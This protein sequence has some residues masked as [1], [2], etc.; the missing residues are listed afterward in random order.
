MKNMKDFLLKR[1][2]LS[3]LI[4]AF[5]LLFVNTAFYRDD[6]RNFEITKNMDI[7]FSIFREVNTFYVDEIDPGIT[8]KKAIDAMLASL[9]PY[10][11][12]YP[13]S[14]IEDFRFM[15][16][17]EYGGIG[18]VVQKRS[19]SAII[20]EIYENT[21]AAKAGLKAGDEIVKIGEV[22]ISTKTLDE[23]SELLKAENNSSINVSVKRLNHANL[24][25]FS[26]IPEKVDIPSVSYAGWVSDE[27][28]YIR[29]TQFTENSANEFTAAL[30]SLQTEKQM[31]GL[32]I[33]LRGN[34]GGLLNDAVNIVN[35]F[36]PR[37]QL[38][39]ETKGKV[40]QWNAKYYAEF[41]PLFPDL[42]LVV[43]VNRSSASA[44]EIVSGALQDL[45]RAVVV[46][47][48][49]YGKG[50]VQTTRKIV[51]NSRMKVTTAKYYI[52]SGRCI[53]ALDYS[54]R[55]ADG[56][57]SHV[58]DSLISEYFTKASRSVHDGAG[59]FPDILVDTSEFSVNFQKLVNENYIFDFA[60]EFSSKNDSIASPEQFIL[61]D[62]QLNVFF[63][64]LKTKNFDFESKS[65]ALLAQLYAQIE[66]ENR[67]SEFADELGLMQSKL[68]DFDESIK[69]LDKNLIVKF[70]GG[71]IASR[72]Y[73]QTGRI[74]FQIR[75]DNA[76]DTALQ[77]I[78]TSVLYRKILNGEYG[79]HLKKSK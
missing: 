75:H 62:E 28:G 68:N 7:F 66:E 56:S 79:N 4:A 60:T 3:V 25:S 43:L 47:E 59:I 73:Y 58:P 77:I 41:E 22:D 67:L 50:L 34:P 27:V 33:D 5:L 21:S 31:K 8:I 64:Y 2:L 78:N 26:I 54:N 40:Q 36:V 72:F 42:P 35:L 38:I 52:P 32:I 13:E 44:S 12:Y 18:A 23:I 70:L 46:G 9:D 53:Q 55:N 11:V 69:R 61:S 6:P 16:T 48:R 45:D 57:V 29:F 39:V 49:T 71:E 74:K 17:G 15:T 30:S 19:N 65:S 24:L 51:Y 63:S 37:G 20:V 1:K 14:Q 76:V 10:T